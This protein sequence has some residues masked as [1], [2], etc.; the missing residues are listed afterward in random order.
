M[1]NTPVSKQ[2]TSF[3]LSLAFCAALNAALVIAKEKNSAVH[4]WM[5]KI[6]GHHWV[7]HAALILI[8]FV[9]LGFALGRVKMAVNVLTAFVLAGTIAGVLILLAFYVIAD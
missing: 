6:T 3:G 2:T 9:I 1:E 5:Q 8:L 4:Q 7:T